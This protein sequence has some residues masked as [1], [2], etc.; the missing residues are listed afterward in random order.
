M[1]GTVGFPVEFKTQS[2]N[3]RTATAR[4]EKGRSDNDLQNNTSAGDRRRSSAT[5]ELRGVVVSQFETQSAQD[6]Y[7]THNSVPFAAQVL[8][9]ML[10]QSAV[11]TSSAR[12]AYARSA[13]SVPSGIC[14]NRL[15]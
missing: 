1:T 2:P 14:F 11:E 15:A 8:S 9:Q 10:G 6:R 12:A 13:A 5:N 4:A 3:W 7:S